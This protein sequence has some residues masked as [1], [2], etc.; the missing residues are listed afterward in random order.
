MVKRNWSAILF[1]AAVIAF[2]T[3]DY[4]ATRRSEPPTA[5]CTLAELSRKVPPP[6]RLAVVGPAY[7]RRLAWIGSIPAFTVRSGPPCYVF[8]GAGQ[9]VDWCPETAEGWPEQ[10]M[11]SWTYHQQPISLDEALRWCEQ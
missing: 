5:H 2:F 3:N 8:D 6:S 10:Y 1:A 9:L 4:F 7:E 11:V